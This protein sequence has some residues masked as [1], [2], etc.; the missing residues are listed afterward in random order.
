MT[1]MTDA[2]HDELEPQRVHMAPLWM[3]RV[4]GFFGVD[5]YTDDHEDA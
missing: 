3:R 5:T 1:R 4:F 2:E